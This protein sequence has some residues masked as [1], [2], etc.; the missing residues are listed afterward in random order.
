MRA[1]VCVRKRRKIDLCVCVCARACARVCVSVVFFIIF[2]FSF[3]AMEWKGQ[4]N[5]E[6]EFF[7]YFFCG[8][9]SDVCEEMS[10]F[11]VFR[12]FFLLCNTCH[13]FVLSFSEF[14]CSGIR[15]FHCVCV[16]VVRSLFLV[17]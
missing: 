4:I 14:F 8:S 15:L 5:T 12:R 10:F 11:C 16:H 2:I 6:N 1:R 3:H 9:K 7:L 13:M 17:S